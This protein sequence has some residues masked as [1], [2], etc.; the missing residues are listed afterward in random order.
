MR[1]RALEAARF[2]ERGFF[3]LLVLA[4]LAG[5]A[6]P[7]W[8]RA[9]SGAVIPLFA[10]MMFAVSLT[11]HA[12]DVG[13]ALTDPLALL[14]ATLAIFVPLPLIARFAAPAVFGPGP[15]AL[16]FV[17]LAALPTD[18]SAPLFTAMGRGNT[19]LTAVLNAIVTAASPV[20]LPLWFLALTGLRLQVPVAAL[21]LE[22]VLVV[23]VPTVGGV[24]LRTVRPALG[25]YDSV[26]QA[27]AS[28]VYLLLVGIVVSQDAH[29]LLRLAPLELVAVV[30]GVLVVNCLGY[31][32]GLLPWWV[33][34][35]AHR[36]RLAYVLAVGEKEFSVA[37]AVVY[38]GGLER[39]LLVPAVVA[40]IL[41][42][43]T[44]AVLA[45]RHRR[46]RPN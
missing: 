16:G 3:P 9:L 28:L 4:V 46:H 38:A 41:Q 20:I 1:A 33:S 31:L 45:R 11:F 24:T 37:V 15:L 44:A 30:A 12:G 8:G 17:L 35:R 6:V 29:N 18:I 7:G 2:L 25:Q 19:A 27:A 22:L 14:V 39:G 5:L 43:V 32:L 26:W 21:V 10:L 42:V 13:A 34:R 23:L 36:D 40:S